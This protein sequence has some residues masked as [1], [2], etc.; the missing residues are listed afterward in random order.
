MLTPAQEELLTEIYDL[1]LKL[2]VSRK[3]AN[4]QGDWNRVN[5]L[6]KEI[7]RVEAQR[8]SIRQWE[9]RWAGSA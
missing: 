9:Q 5:A 4:D 8:T 7:A 2:Y 6:E 3:E 1:L